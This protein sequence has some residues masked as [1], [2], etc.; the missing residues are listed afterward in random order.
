MENVGKAPWK[1]RTKLELAVGLVEWCVRLL[2]NWFRRRVLVVADG[3]YAKRPFLQR[4]LATGAVVVS[5]LRKD[6]A[7]FE[8]PDVKKRRGKGRPRKYGKEISL[9]RRGAHRQGWT[10][11]RMI[12]YGREQEIR[13][14]TFL[15]TYPPVGGVIRVVIVKHRQICSQTTRMN[16]SPFSAP[17][18]QPPFTRSLKVWLTALRSSRT[19]VMSRRCLGPMSSRYGMSGAV[20][21]AGTCACGCTRCLN[22]VR[23]SGQAT[24]CVS[25]RTVHGIT[26]LAGRVT[27]TA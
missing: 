13:Y 2:Q 22:C 12:L 3:A 10:T 25:A 24:L 16:G 14:K 9:A 17:M 6:A 21:P 8:L 23:G 20:W 7:L 1:F 15:A 27:Q 18:Q 26:Q 19:F 11:T 4:V 5:R